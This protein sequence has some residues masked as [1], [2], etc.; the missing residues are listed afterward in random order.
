MFVNTFIQRPILA[1][2]C[3]L[4]IILAGAIAIPTMPVAQY[5]ELAPPQISVNAIY[6]GANAQEVESAV[7][8]PLEQAINGVEGIRLAAP[9]VDG[10]ALGSSAFGASGVFVR[11][12]RAA[13]LNNLTSI[14]KNIRQGTLEGFDEGQ[15]VAIGRRLADQLSIH[16]GDNITLVAPKGARIQVVTDDD[17][18][19][20]R[21]A[22]KGKKP[23]AFFEDRFEGAAPTEQ[24]LLL[25][26]A[27]AG[28]RASLAGITREAGAG[29]NAAVGLR[30]LIE[31]GLVYRPSRATYDFALPLFAGYL[32]RRGN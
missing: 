30:R 21:A 24:L 12:I 16:A 20:L 23:V 10:Q 9:V 31:K 18:A 1:S 15:G 2:V 3:S 4:V 8:T 11:G 7:T 19:S 26:M 17:L 27:R 25:A 22:T 6:T 29:I 5:P 14:A 13:D 28:G 32:R